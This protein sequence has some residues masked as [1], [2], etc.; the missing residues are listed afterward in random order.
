MPG[1]SPTA[2]DILTLSFKE[3]GI[4]GVGQ[5]LLAEDSNGG[6]MATETLACAII[7]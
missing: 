1:N 5:T 2:R 3:A 6:T 7:N 4:L